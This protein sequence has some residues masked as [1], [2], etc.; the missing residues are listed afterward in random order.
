MTKLE[1]SKASSKAE[2]ILMGMV[3]NVNSIEEAT[4]ILD[5]I[6]TVLKQD[7]KGQNVIDKATQFSTNAEIKH[8]GIAQSEDMTL[9]NLT[10]ITDEDR[11]NN[12]TYDLF[13]PDGVFGYV[14]NI[15]CPDCSELGYSYYKE[16]RTGAKRIA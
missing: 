15:E 4:F 7:F 8:I 16:T 3:Q 5:Y 6:A 10:L 9:I 11:E 14:Y 13:D 2:L 12:N 1:Q